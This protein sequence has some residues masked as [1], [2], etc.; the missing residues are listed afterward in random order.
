MVRSQ[1][2]GVGAGL[3]HAGSGRRRPREPRFG[4]GPAAPNAPTRF[5]NIRG[6]VTAVSAISMRSSNAEVS[7][8][9][10]KTPSAAAIRRLSRSGS[11]ASGSRSGWPSR[12]C[13]WRQQQRVTAESSPRANDRIRG[14][15]ST[16]PVT[17]TPLMLGILSLKRAVTAA[18]RMSD[19]SPGDSAARRPADG[20]AGSAES[21]Q[22]PARRSPHDPGSRDRPAGWWLASR[23]R[24][25]A[26]MA[27]C[28]LRSSGTTQT[29]SLRSASDSEIVDIWCFS[30]R[31][32]TMPS[33]FTSLWRR[34]CRAAFN[35]P[36]PGR[37]GDGR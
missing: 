26:V 18:S 34:D 30:T 3:R 37:A 15:G 2:I 13:R 17:T 14:S 25:G 6:V 35:A 9:D 1:S 20:R 7:M 31:F 11:G 8:T 22:R 19:R 21:S 10:S 16:P 4:A 27:S 12:T 28:R 29:G 33:K 5:S 23:R 32:T 24:S 36:R